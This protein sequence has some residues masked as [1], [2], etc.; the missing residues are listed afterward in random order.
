MYEKQILIVSQIIHLLQ[1]V[2][3]STKIMSNKYDI[4]M[5][6]YSINI[7]LQSAYDKIE[8]IYYKYILKPELENIIYND[9]K[10]SLAHSK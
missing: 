9:N 8:K 6:I 5:I 10:L 4:N 2:I 7:V 3:K 1:N